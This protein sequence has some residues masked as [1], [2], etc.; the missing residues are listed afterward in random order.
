MSPPLRIERE[1]AI[2]RVML[3]RPPLNVLDRAT[4][5]ALAAAVGNLAAEHDVA[6]LVISGGAARGFSAGVE[7]ADH[8]PATVAGMLEDFHAAIRALQGC[9]CVTVAAI[10]GLALGGGFE[11]ALACD[12]IVAEESSRLGLP[13]IA[14]GC[15]PPVAAALLPARAGWAVACELVL[16]GE[17]I[18][19][20]RAHA[21]GLVNR[22]CADGGLAA[23]TDELVGT[24]TR[25][26]PAVLREAKRALREGASQPFA[27]ALRRIERRYL[28][29]LMKL[30]DSGEG[31]RAFLEK[32]PPVWRNE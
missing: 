18:A 8:V 26:S 32:R 27:S 17:P 12:L 3:D 24:L 21:L 14:L 22:V 28:D 7:V 6:V 10:H 31:I 11:L 9:G 25:H 5:R 2:A 4:S 13:E 16:A 20:A 23:A 30:A 15:Y 1:G 29:D 19:A